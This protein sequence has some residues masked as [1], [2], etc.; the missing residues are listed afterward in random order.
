M[1]VK[2]CYFPIFI[3]KDAMSKESNHIEGFAPEIAWIK[4]P[5]TEDITSTDSTIGI[6][7]TSETIMYP[8]Y[9]KWIRTHRD[10]PLKMN[11]WCNVVRW[12]FKNP[13]PFIR[14][15]EFLWQEGHSAFATK[16]EACAEILDILTMYKSVYEDLCAV[17]VVKGYKT[18]LEKFAGADYTTTLEVF[19][20]ESGKSI[21]S[22]TAHGLGQNFSKMFDIQYDVAYS[23]N[24]KKEVE[25]RHVWQNSWGL[26]TRSLGVIVMTHSDDKGLVL[27]P[28][29]APIQI[30][31]IPLYFTK[32]DNTKTDQYCY[33]LEK[34][35]ED[36]N[37]RVFL[38]TDTIHRAGHKFNTYELRG[39]PIRI[40]I[41]PKDIEKESVTYC[42]RDTSKKS[43]VKINELYDTIKQQLQ[44][45]HENLYNS[46]KQRQESSLVKVFNWNDFVS[47]V[48][49]KKICVAPFCNKST[50]EKEISSKKVGVKSLCYPFDQQ[51]I[52]NLNCFNCNEK[53]NLLCYFG[54]SY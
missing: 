44:L 54:K 43:E 46:A 8:Y 32:A 36:A 47:N 29:I 50:C 38:D 39:V 28:K 41:G 3:T 4:P 15:R 6:R 35:L 10:L 21:Q 16:D 5:K 17:P 49:N 34:T 24:S 26:S 51:I 33:E 23:D 42:R 25:K 20:P 52:D 2:N 48:D 14:G 27:P 7:P 12:E 11:Q 31:I 40:E 53:A 22:C 18:E 37:F 1:N 19:I 13:I 9:S 45:M 30:V